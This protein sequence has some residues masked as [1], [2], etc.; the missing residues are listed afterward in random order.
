VRDE[1]KDLPLH[2][3]S[4]VGGRSMDDRAQRMNHRPNVRRAQILPGG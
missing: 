4:E 2:G 3:R 1:V